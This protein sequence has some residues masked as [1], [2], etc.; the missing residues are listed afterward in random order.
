[1]KKAEST[2]HKTSDKTN[3]NV[4]LARGIELITKKQQRKKEEQPSKEEKQRVEQ[5]KMR[6]NG[7]HLQRNDN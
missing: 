1:M 5:T 4:V 6:N 7:G 3:V 2:R